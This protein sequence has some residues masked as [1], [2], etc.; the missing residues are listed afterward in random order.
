MRFFYL[1]PP[2]GDDPLLGGEQQVPPGGEQ[3]A[4][5]GGEQQVPPGDNQQQP[6]E[7]NLQPPPGDNQSTSRK[8]KNGAT[9]QILEVADDTGEL[10]V[11]VTK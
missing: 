5:P 1:Q 4:P 2:L 3:Q 9:M 6:P 11:K 10:T 7:E 8:L